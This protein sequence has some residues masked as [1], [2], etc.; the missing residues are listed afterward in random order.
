MEMLLITGLTAFHSS[1][2]DESSTS[3]SGCG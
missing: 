3:L 1:R 2:V